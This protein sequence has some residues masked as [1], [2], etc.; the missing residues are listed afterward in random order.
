[1]KKM[2]MVKKKNKKVSLGKTLTK[3]QKRKKKTIFPRFLKKLLEVVTKIQKKVKR[4][5]K[6]SQTEKKL[7]ELVM[8]MLREDPKSMTVKTVQESLSQ[9]TMHITTKNNS[10][11]KQML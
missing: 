6:K 8:S 10:F 2:R 3:I 5:T 9:N 7:V 11:Q 1:M 4:K